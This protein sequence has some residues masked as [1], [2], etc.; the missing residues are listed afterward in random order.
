M[1]GTLINMIIEERNMDES[2]DGFVGVG[3]INDNA[4]F[5]GVVIYDIEFYTML[6]PIELNT[7]IN[8]AYRF[9]SK[10]ENVMII[11]H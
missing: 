11:I 2:T 5:R 1:K 9:M 6:T 3:S 8:D 4:I 10:E 7:A